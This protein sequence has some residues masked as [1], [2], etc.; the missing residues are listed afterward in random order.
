M[1]PA[2]TKTIG[3]KQY[4]ETDLQISNPTS[5]TYQLHGGNPTVWNEISSGLIQ[6]GKY[7]IGPTPG[8]NKRGYTIAHLLKE[9]FPDICCGTL[10]SE[11]ETKSIFALP[12]FKTRG[13]VSG[14]TGF[15]N[16]QVGDYG[17]R[18]QSVS[19]QQI[20]NYFNQYLADKNDTG[21]RL[22]WYDPNN[23]KIQLK[24]WDDVYEKYSF[25]FVHEY[26]MYRQAEASLAGSLNPKGFYS[27]SSQEL[28]E[29][30]L[31]AM[32]KNRGLST[33][34]IKQELLDSGYTS[35]Q[36]NA[37]LNQ[38]EYYANTPGGSGGS[39]GSGGTGGT[40]GTGHGNGGGSN[41]GRVD[42]GL[43]TL[44]SD[45][46]TTIQIQ[47]SR[48]L[49][50][51]S[52]D[53]GNAFIVKNNAEKD[54]YLLAPQIFQLVPSTNREFGFI[55]YIPNRYIFIHKP[56]EI[57]YSGLGSE[58]VSID[59]NGGFS[60]VDWKKFQLLQISFTFVI[61]KTADGL[62][63]HV[64]D[65]IQLLRKIAQTP[66]PVS[67]F[68]FDSMFT[69]EL[70]YD[71]DNFNRSNNLPTGIQ[72]VI[73]DFSITAQQRDSSMR[74]TRAQASMTLQEIPIEKQELISMPRLVPRGDKKPPPPPDD[75][76][77]QFRLPSGA[78]NTGFVDPSF[79]YNPSDIG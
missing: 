7:I 75:P 16:L 73:T 33:E 37:F 39:G 48:N 68:N 61:A 38:K 78:L 3:N 20:I 35:A 13:V 70:R 60:F 24:T 42:S 6:S 77:G 28:A 29:T 5:R 44:Q 51:D 9:N 57:Q 43:P 76:A 36:I 52:L 45:S 62:L 14:A 23:R 11:D 31:W 2:L 66:Y 49:F 4:I 40:G 65:E 1:R 17:P 10:D 41:T 63:N 64:E 34:A 18:F 54:K 30:G 21:K 47:R 69:Q 22:Y 56:N 46:L 25:Y 79:N 8:Q 59:R 74:I 12:Q 19:K 55:E 71:S 53:V 58:W 72:F 15:N 26:E 50:G 67:F 27:G 32:F